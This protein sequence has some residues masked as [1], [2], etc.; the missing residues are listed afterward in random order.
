MNKLEL[1]TAILDR[2][3]AMGITWGDRITQALDIMNAADQFDLDLEDW[4][5]ADD[6]NFAHDFIGIQNHMNRETM[7]CENFFVPRFAYRERRHAHD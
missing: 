5:N 7:R 2:A 3:K 6:E 4:L 1:Q